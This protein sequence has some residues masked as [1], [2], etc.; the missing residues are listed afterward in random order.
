MNITQD[1]EQWRSAQGLRPVTGPKHPRLV[2]VSNEVWDNLLQL[3]LDHHL[4]YRGKPSVP[5]LL[6]L[7]AN[8]TIAISK[9]T[10]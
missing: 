8:G 1:Y 6:E 5:H 9:P 2:N 7:I 4:L 10:G 3:C